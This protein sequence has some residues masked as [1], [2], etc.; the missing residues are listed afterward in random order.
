MTLTLLLFSLFKVAWHYT[1]WRYCDLRFIL[2][3]QAPPRTLQKN[4][5][6]ATHFITKQHNDS[7]SMIQETQA[8]FSPGHASCSHELNTAGYRSKHC[9]LNLEHFKQYKS[10]KVT[11]ILNF[12]LTDLWLRTDLFRLH[13]ALYIN[14]KIEGGKWPSLLHQ[15]RSHLVLEIKYQTCQSF[16][17]QGSNHQS[18]LLLSVA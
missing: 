18:C 5:P 1:L 14:W 12:L 4:Q 9:S 15:Q 3:T 8:Y 6:I 2:V 16:S 13:T 17:G 10:N 7:L 11:I